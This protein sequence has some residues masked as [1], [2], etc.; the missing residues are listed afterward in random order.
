MRY[1]K[2]LA[3][4]LGCFPLDLGPY[5]PKSVCFLIVYWLDL[6]QP[7]PFQVNRIR[8]FSSIRNQ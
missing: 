8:S 4:D 1:F 7:I 2:T 3:Y 5:H 6:S